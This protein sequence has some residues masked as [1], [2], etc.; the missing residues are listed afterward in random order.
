MSKDR[1]LSLAITLLQ[2]RSVKES[3]VVNRS[4]LFCDVSKERLHADWFANP[5]SGHRTPQRNDASTKRFAF[6]I[7]RVFGARAKRSSRPI[8]MMRPFVKPI[9]IDSICLSPRQKES[10]FNLRGQRFL[11]TVLYHSLRQTLGNAAAAVYRRKQIS[12]RD[13]RPDWMRKSRNYTIDQTAIIRNTI[14]ST[15]E[16]AKLWRSLVMMV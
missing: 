15:T 1:L 7:E 10:L 2:R 9:E 11:H 5:Y 12:A 3:M 13:G 4:W 6:V 14:S 8:A 16:K